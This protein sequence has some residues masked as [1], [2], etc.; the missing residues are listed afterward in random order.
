MSEISAPLYELL[1]KDTTWDWGTKKEQ[2]FHILKM[3]LAEAPV[4]SL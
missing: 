3:K 4:L 2:A 1:Q